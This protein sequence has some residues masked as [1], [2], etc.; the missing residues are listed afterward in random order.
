MKKLLAVTL[1]SSVAS[2]AM[3]AGP[4]AQVTINGR[5]ID[6][7]CLVNGQAAPAQI[8]VTLDT[9]QRTALSAFT[10]YG[11]KPF[12]IALTN[13]PAATTTM[14]WDPVTNV[15]TTTGT[16]KNTIVGGTNV[17]VRILKAD[18]TTPINLVT[19]P[20]VSFTGTSQ[21]YNFNAQ[22][23]PVSAP[24]AGDLKTIAQLF[25]TYN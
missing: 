11:T 9:V 17:N 18:G 2:V 16:L 20:G 23:Y 6:G 10:G 4:D 7:T 5:V 25:L 15:D 22:Y 21:S 19:D 8:T 1:L 13:C 24:T 3:A 14:K 12:S